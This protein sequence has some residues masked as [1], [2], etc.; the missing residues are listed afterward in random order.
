MLAD[1]AFRRW[2]VAGLDPTP[3]TAA[4]YVA[5][6]TAEWTHDVRCSWA[7]C[8]PTTGGMRGEIGV[9]DLDR[10]LGVGELAVATLPDARRQGLMRTVVPAVLRFAF[11]PAA[12]GGL[13]LHRVAYRHADDN[14][15]SEALARASGFAY[16]GRERGALLCDGERRDGLRWARL[17]TDD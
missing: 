6:R 17:A 3:A 13:G 9:K 14:T 12:H 4:A 16:E 11:A 1:P 10:T 2:G 5:R 15:A 8:E 7:V